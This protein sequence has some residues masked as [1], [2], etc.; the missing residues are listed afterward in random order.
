MRYFLLCFFLSVQVCLT[1]AQTAARCGATEALEWVYKNDPSAR[2]RVEQLLNAANQADKMAFATRYAH[3]SAVTYTIPVVFHVVHLGGAE[4]IPDAQIVNAMQILNNDFAKLN[5]DT[6]N[7]LAIFKPIAANTNIQFAL[8]T[9]D[10]QGHCS[11][12][13]TRH[14]DA[15]T[16]WGNPDLSNY[17]FQWPAN[18]YLNIYVV[19]ALAPGVAGYSFYPGT[20]PLSMDG[21]VILHNY[22]GAIGSSSPI[23]SRS[24]THEV[25]HWLNLAH[26]WGNNNNPGQVCGDD[27]VS[28]TP[29]TKG[30]TWCNLN[31][32]ACTPGITENVQNYMEYSFCS[33]MFTQGQATRMQ[34]ALNSANGNRNNVWTTANLIAT[35][36]I[37]PLVNCAP[38]ANYVMSQSVTCMNAP[39]S[40]LDASYNATI[41]AWQWSS[42]AASQ[43]STLQN[44][45]LTF[46]NSG[47]A[48]VKLKV[49]NAFGS[50]SIVKNKIYVMANGSNAGIPNIVE[51]FE[52]NTFP[53]NRWF[54]SFPQFGSAFVSTNLAAATGSTSVYI[55]NFNDNPNESINLF[56]P[57]FMITNTLNLNVQ[58]KTAFAQQ[59]PSNADRLRVYY[60]F[61]CGQT[62]NLIFSKSGTAL[63]NGVLPQFNTAFVPQANQWTTHSIPLNFMPNLETYFRFEYTT[64]NV[65]GPGNNFYLDDINVSN[66]AIGLNE[67]T[68]QTAFLEVT[69]NPASTHLTASLKGWQ[70]GELTWRLIDVSARVL[71]EMKTQSVNFTQLEVSRYQRGIYFL[72]VS[73][74]QTRQV[75]KVIIE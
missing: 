14:Y 29:I 45:Q 63:A 70:S 60:T 28:D 42:S 19:K 34:T 41:A 12:G 6:T 8:A 51:S 66:N 44:G 25:G 17:K 11:N 43:N 49:S 27:G 5:A 72:E 24:L 46:I 62:W 54:G 35:G 18:R 22:V 39:V 3:A 30:N 7:T 4:N 55:N 61:D 21:I 37:N 2:N 50:D 64:D 59:F 33:N 67:N 69:P 31:V 23:G 56:T 75:K 52:T 15:V 13:I 73:N 9:K 57:A 58:F 53:N 40:F 38:Q 32:A 71:T 74:S 36:V 68:M 10:P 47:P 48:S 1:K 26:I 16:N 20:V 65:N